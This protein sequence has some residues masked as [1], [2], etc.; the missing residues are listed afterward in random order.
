MQV[1]GRSHPRITLPD[2]VSRRRLLQYS[3][4]AAVALSPATTWAVEGSTRPEFPPNVGVKFGRDGRVIPFPGNTIIC[5]LDQQGDRAACFD[6]LLD[7][8]REAAGVPFM[9]KVTML[10]PSSYH[11]T[12][13]GAADDFNR[14]P[15]DW[16]NGVPLDMPIKECHRVVADRLRTF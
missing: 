2:S 4:A 12:V 6:A 10:P 13:F 7:I 16:P 1:L 15:G 9:T 11:M 8:Y 3:A 14:R 5:H